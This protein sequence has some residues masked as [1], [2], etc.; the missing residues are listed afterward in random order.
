VEHALKVAQ[1]FEYGTDEH[2]IA[3]LH[4]VIEDEQA[5]ESALRATY[6]ARIVDTV[7]ELTRVY[8]ETYAEYIERLVSDE[9]IAVKI[10]DVE[11]NLARSS[12]YHSLH[13]RYH[14]ALMALLVK[15]QIAD[16]LERTHVRF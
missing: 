4:D 2:M 7:V 12:K 11:E 8:E 15:R 13:K 6:P 3:L 1:H 16:R 5:T 14:R 9:A 10:A